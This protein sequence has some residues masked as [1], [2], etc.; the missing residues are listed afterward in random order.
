MS[1]NPTEPADELPAE[2][3]EAI[4][5]WDDEYI[6]RVAHQ[7]VYSYDLEK[8][9]RLG[10]QRWDL[11]A[12]MRVVSHKQVLHPALSYADHETEEF[13]FLRREPRPTVD[14][15]ERLVELGHEVADERIVADEEHFETEISFVLLA[16]E[17]SDDVREYV[18]GFRDRTLLRFGYYGH[19]EINLVVVVP[20]EETQVAS[21][22]ADIVNG[23][24]LWEAEPD[25]DA[26]F[27]SRVVDRFRR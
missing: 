18:S 8:D 2:I 14:N 3:R 11:Y 24:T 9:H 19:Y 25:S 27:V 7:L 1:E 17:L 16:D 13:V 10:G 4:P 6:D 15:L 21:E 23:V 12:E 26:G 22:V 20:E 5:E